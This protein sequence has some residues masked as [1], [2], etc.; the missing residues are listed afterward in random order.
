ML[1]NAIRTIANINSYVYIGSNQ[2]VACWMF[3]YIQEMMHV[4]CLCT[5]NNAC[6]IFV[7]V[8]EV[9]RVKMVL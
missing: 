8:Q 3:V 7:Y 1:A 2:S 6:W 4:G 9:V 5:G